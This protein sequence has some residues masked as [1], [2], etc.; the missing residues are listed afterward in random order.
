MN[1][2]AVYLAAIEAV[3]ALWLGTTCLATLV[4]SAWWRRRQMR[5]AAIEPALRSAIV[6]YI[7]GAN[8]F[9]V[10]EQYVRTSA[11]E[12]SE[13][14]FSFRHA[15]SGAALDRLC[16]LAIEL[17]LLQR[18]LDDAE[19]RD[20]MARRNAF[21]RLAFVCA[22]EPCRR[23]VGDRLSE[24][25]ED[26]D[27]DI[28]LTAAAAL[29]QTGRPADVE[30]VFRLALSESLLVRITLA[31]TLRP[32]AYGLC[33]RVIPET[34]RS[35]DVSRI[36]AA[37]ELLRAWERALPIVG[38]APLMGHRDK[39]VRLEAFPLAPLVAPGPDIENEI[40][41]GLGDPDPQIAAAAARTAARLHLDKA[42]P[43]LARCARTASP[44]VIEAAASALAEMQPAGWTTLQ[45]LRHNPNPATA[46]AAGAALER[47][48]RKAGA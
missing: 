20:T 3:L 11:R 44:L 40:L 42:L 38:L 9:T 45:E 32:H 34:L 25:L 47:A 18:W 13:Q 39:R 23:Q 24:A 29:A 22:Y 4:R 37:L 8:D 6:D 48:R 14:M 35:Q 17:T 1:P 16:S 19:T 28:R 36:L 21:R 33:E 2:F 30:R 10:L 12:I 31:E 7:G 46:A 41:A 27:R 26:A 5:S 43:A 15:V